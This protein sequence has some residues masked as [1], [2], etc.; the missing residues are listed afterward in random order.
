[1]I[2]YKHKIFKGFFEVVSS[3]H[4]YWL[5]FCDFLL[6]HCTGHNLSLEIDMFA[7]CVEKDDI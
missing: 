6:R 7:S 2:F 5:S 3:K 4:L 1:M